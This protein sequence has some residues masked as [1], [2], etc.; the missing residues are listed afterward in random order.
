MNSKDCLF[1]RA[2]CRPTFV[3]DGAVL[4]DQDVCVFLRLC[5]GKHTAPH[6]NTRSEYFYEGCELATIGVV[7]NN[8]HRARTSWRGNKQMNKYRISLHHLLSR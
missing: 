4:V 8:G 2:G 1:R 3:G 6:N 7:L 5:V